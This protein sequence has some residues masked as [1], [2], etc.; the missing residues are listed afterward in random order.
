MVIRRAPLEALF[1]FEG[2]MSHTALNAVDT[3]ASVRSV[4]G[5][6]AWNRSLTTT[7]RAGTH[8]N[9]ANSKTAVT[10]AANPCPKL[11]TLSLIMQLCRVDT[12]NVKYHSFHPCQRPRRAPRT[13]HPRDRA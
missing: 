8:G 12:L 11:K 3:P 7:A 5:T 13:G 1:C 6:E 2:A 4:T 10:A 9:P